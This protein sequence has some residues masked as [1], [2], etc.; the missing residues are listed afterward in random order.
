MREHL[1]ASY[2]TRTIWIALAAVALLFVLTGGTAH[3]NCYSSSETSQSYLDSAADGEAG[4][5]PEI[6]GV[7]AVTDSACGIGIGAAIAGAPNAGDLIADESVGIYMN[8][9]GNPATGSPTWDGADKVVITVGQIGA[10]LPPGLGVWN[11]STF[12][13][14]G[15][16]SLP[17][18][19]AAGFL[20]TLDQLGIPAPGAIGI[21]TISLYQG[22]YDNYS[23]FA[24]EVSSSPFSFPVSFSTTPTPRAPTVTA[25]QSTT[26]PVG[27]RACR[28][29]SVRGLT[30]TSA[31]RKLARAGCR[32]R[33]VRVR[34]RL[35]SGRAISTSPGAGR[36]AGGTVV[37]RIS[38]G[39]RARASAAQVGR[40]GAIER[41]MRAAEEAK[42]S[43]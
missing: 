32:Y 42:S 26:A 13:F 10:D 12:S 14:A 38:R 4:L 37:L 43:G 29:P 22:L 40:Y 6:L 5:A 19:G 7:A 16:P 1:S 17:A 25:P 41:A 33:M 36:H 23:D 35:R 15:S 18:V 8:T 28:I 31:G 3:A 27:R 21:E 30:A 9:D 24:P 2:R 34:N 39:K 20:S 11:G